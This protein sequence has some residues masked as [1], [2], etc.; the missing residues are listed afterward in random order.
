MALFI[1]EDTDSTFVV[2]PGENTLQVADVTLT[3]EELNRI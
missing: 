1:A 2:R 3:T